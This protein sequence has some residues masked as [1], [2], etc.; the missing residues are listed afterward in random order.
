MPAEHPSVADRAL[1]HRLT[2]IRQALRSIRLSP[3][4]WSVAA[5][6]VVSSPDKY[7]VVT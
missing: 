5:D 6:T 1:V 4:E 3:D 7:C 2:D